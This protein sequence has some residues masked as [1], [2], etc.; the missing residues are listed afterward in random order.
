MRGVRSRVQSIILASARS[1]QHP[2]W[3]NA[4][5]I[6]RANLLWKRI[7][8]SRLSF[9]KDYTTIH[10]KK[11]KADMIYMSKVSK[12]SSIN[13]HLCRIT[14]KSLQEHRD[15]RVSRYFRLIM[16]TPKL[17]WMKCRV[18]WSSQI[19][20]RLLIQKDQ[21]WKIRRWSRICGAFFNW[22]YRNNSNDPENP[23]NPKNP[24]IPN[25][26]NNPK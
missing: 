12:M 14:I 25:N 22:N 5:R 8:K 26:L 16:T 1:R 10:I 4:W 20:F 15:L 24:N 6:E 18:S 2:N 17:K 9:S 19:I 23:D 21:L 7:P 3:K 11:R 13:A